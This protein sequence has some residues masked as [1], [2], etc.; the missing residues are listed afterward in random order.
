MKDDSI[1]IK[2]AE[3]GSSIV[4]WDKQHYLR[5]FS[6]QLEDDKVYKKIE[7]DPINRQTKKYI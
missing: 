5:E 6:N 3:K 2:P 4:I 1:M 7:K